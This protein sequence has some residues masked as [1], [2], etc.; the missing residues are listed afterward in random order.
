MQNADNENKMFKKFCYD[1]FE[2]ILSGEQIK[3]KTPL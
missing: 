1:F 3:P 2:R